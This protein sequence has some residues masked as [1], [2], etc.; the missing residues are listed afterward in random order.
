ML[1]HTW[2]F[3]VFFLVVLTGVLLLRRLATPLLMWLLTASYVFYGSWNPYYLALIVF[4]TLVDYLAVQAMARLGGRRFWLVVSLINNLG[5]LGFFKYANFFIENLNLL[6][7]Q[8]RLGIRLTEAGDWMPFGWQYMLPVGISFYTFQSLS[9]TID[10]YRGRLPREDNLLRFATYVAFFPQLVAG[11][12]ERSSSLLPQLAD[13]PRMSLERASSGASLFLVGFFKK[14]A[15][16]NYLA[17]YVERVYATPGSSSAS[18]C[19]LGTI[20]FAWQIY[21]DFSAY[22]DMARGVA[23]IIGY[24]L[25]VNFR[26]P[27]LATGLS[28]FWSRWHISLS[29]WFRD[30]VYIPVGGS[31]GGPKRTHL[32]LLFVFLVSGFWHGSAWNF[33]IWGALH[34]IGTVLSRRWE[35]TSWYQDRVPAILKQLAVFAFVCLGWVFFRAET[36]S[37]ALAMLRQIATGAW[38]DPSCPLLMIGLMAAIW[39]YQAIC[40][41]KWRMVVA[42]PMLQVPLAVLMI[43]YVLLCATGGG[44]FIYFQF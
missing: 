5:L 30:Y 24:D 31:R 32:N 1:F 21:F 23:R 20:C 35:A 39:L 17:M 15:V 4:S 44:E 3:A 7:S 38:G 26:H 12:I 9:Y 36:V 40:E 43:V 19:V 2:E 22:T 18:A 10:F 27:Y 13:E 33:V 42:A 25:M 11:P 16:A 28:D 34:G 41:S 14:V 29:T 8:L 6:A 37:D